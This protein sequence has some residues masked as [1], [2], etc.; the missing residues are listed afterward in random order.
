M[1][2]SKQDIPVTQITLELSTMERSTH[3]RLFGYYAPSDV[4]I[5]AELLEKIKHYDTAP[6]YEVYDR[7]T[8]CYYDVP[9]EPTSLDQWQLE[10]QQEEELYKRELVTLLSGV[11]SEYVI[12]KIHSW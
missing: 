6:S 2:A 8:D 1:N 9:F 11:T 4:Y 12:I 10:N 5:T 7:E 3:I